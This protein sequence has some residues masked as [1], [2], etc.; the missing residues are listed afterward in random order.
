[1]RH[2]PKM[3]MTKESLRLILV[4]WLASPLICAQKLEIVSSKPQTTP[5][6][7]LGAVFNGEENE[8][9]VQDFG[10]RSTADGKVGQRR[11]S[12]WNLSNGEMKRNPRIDEYP[13]ATSSYPC[14]RIEFVPSMNSVVVCSQ[15]SSLE[16]FDCGSL[17]LKEK[18]AL[19]GTIFDF[20]FD[21]GTNTLL[22]LSVPTD[23]KVHIASYSLSDRTQ[24]SD[25]VL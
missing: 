24:K 1:M 2:P 12:S 20:A 6:I 17:A 3:Q 13:V 25:F 14:G 11:I 9:F 4:L 21:E 19:S 15:G 22:V 16:F 10:F 5:G 7:V 8:F 23:E 18:M